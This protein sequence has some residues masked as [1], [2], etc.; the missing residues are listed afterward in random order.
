MRRLVAFLILAVAVLSPAR[1]ED[2]TLFTDSEQTPSAADLLAQLRIDTPLTAAIT[3]GVAGRRS[4]VPAV[5]DDGQAPLP[6]FA[7]LPDGEIVVEPDAVL[8]AVAF[9]SSAPW[10]VTWARAERVT[11]EMVQAALGPV[12]APDPQPDEGLAD[13]FHHL[14]D[15]EVDPGAAFEVDDDPGSEDDI[16]PTELEQEPEGV[17][18]DDDEPGPEDVDPDDDPDP[19]SEL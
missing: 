14:L 3:Q 15:T 2:L 9:W 6:R 10:L 17:G 11:P 5:P 12:P 18:W 19:D 4:S 8:D 7:T 16:S 1:A 13:S